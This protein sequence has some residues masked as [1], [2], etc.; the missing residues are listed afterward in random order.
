MELRRGYEHNENKDSLG[1]TNLSQASQASSHDSTPANQFESNI[2]KD[3]VALLDNNAELGSTQPISEDA[4]IGSLS[5]ELRMA[6]RKVA[7]PIAVVT[8]APISANGSQDGK[9]EQSSS[10]RRKN[11][12]GLLVSS[13][14]TVT[15]KPE[16]YISFNVKL[17]SRTWDAITQ[18]KEFMVHLMWSH[19][20]AQKFAPGLSTGNTASIEPATALD[21]LSKG[22]TIG[23]RCKLASYHKVQDH[24]IVVGNVLE[25]MPRSAIPGVSFEH[26]HLLW[27]EGKWH[28]AKPLQNDT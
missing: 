2:R 12:R 14:N 27:K 25:L 16:P 21:E 19:T 1:Y 28:T 11:L 10:I 26:E 18:S 3:T 7:Y 24:I 22:R 6:M 5:E 17:P 4:P 20:V 9:L 8:S 13:F 23:L 15:L